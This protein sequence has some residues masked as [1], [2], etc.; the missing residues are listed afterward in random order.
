MLNLI[1]SRRSVRQWKSDAVREE[2]VEKVLDAAMNAPSAGN[3][4]PWQFV[5]VT[6]KAV[7]NK[8]A[9]LNPYGGFV[10]DAP[11]A[12][13]VCGDIRLEKF[14]GYWVQDCSAAVENMLLAAHALGL[15]AVWTSVYPIDDRIV[16]F[17][18]LFNLPSEVIPFALIPLGYPRVK[19]RDAS[20]R[21]NPSR[22]RKN[23]W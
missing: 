16:G 10:K 5:V 6:D 23:I 11:V 14:P 19:G 21:F 4:Q 7:L 13:L 2:D 22:V 8:A 12:I 20:S 18:K 17:R 9:G 15:G 3:E 1:K